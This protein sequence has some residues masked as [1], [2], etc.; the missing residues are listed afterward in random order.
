M[1]EGGYDHRARS[2][3]NSLSYETSCNELLVDP[4]VDTEAI[5]PDAYHKREVW[6]YTMF[7]GLAPQQHFPVGGKAK[8]Q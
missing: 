1:R 6:R 8:R 5:V 3:V 2:K 4:H 7:D